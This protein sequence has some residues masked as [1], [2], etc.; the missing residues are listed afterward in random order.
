MRVAIQGFGH[1]PFCIRNLGQ[2]RGIGHPSHNGINGD[3]P[4][5]ELQTQLPNMTFQCSFGGADGP[6]LCPGLVAAHAGHG[7]DP[8]T[9][10]HEFTLDEVLDPIHQAIGHDI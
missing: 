6:V 10:H 7:V 9:G 4:G 3:L 5:S 8:S 1:D 2:C